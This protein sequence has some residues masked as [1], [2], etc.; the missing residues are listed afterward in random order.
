LHPVQDA[1]VRHHGSQCGFCTPGFVMSLFT[2]YQ[3]GGA[4]AADRDAVLTR[5]AGN[6]CRCT[7]YR[8]IVE[9]ALEACAMPPDDRF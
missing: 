7:G 6:L 4:V 1:M 3:E 5:V 2:L 9:A 8:P